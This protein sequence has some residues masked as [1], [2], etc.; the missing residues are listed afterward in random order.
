MA[1]NAWVMAT[2]SDVNAN[3]TNVHI[4]CNDFLSSNKPAKKSHLPLKQVGSV[5]GN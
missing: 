3:A 5:I 1:R 2:G 4:F